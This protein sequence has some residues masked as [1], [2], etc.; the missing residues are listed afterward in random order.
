MVGRGVA[1]SKALR[2]P[3]PC[4]CLWA[5][6]AGIA[7]LLGLGHR[8]AVAGG[9]QVHPHVV[10]C[11]RFAEAGALHM[12]HTITHPNSTIFKYA[13]GSEDASM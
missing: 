5:E 13:Y 1:H 8:S 11:M 9:I 6:T 4:A 10:R 7:G 12:H 2:M 3:V